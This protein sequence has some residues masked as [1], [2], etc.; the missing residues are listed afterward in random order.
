MSCIIPLAACRMGKETR[1]LIVEGCVER[2]Q[3]AKHKTT[4]V[5]SP[6]VHPETEVLIFAAMSKISVE[7]SHVV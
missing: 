6:P 2:S 5:I 4:Q 1:G 7:M 3:I